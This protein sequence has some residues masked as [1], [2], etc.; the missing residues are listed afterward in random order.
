MAETLI[1][2]NPRSAN[3]RAGRNRQQ[4]E[5]VLRARLPFPFDVVYTERQGHATEIAREAAPRCERVV[6]LG[7]DGT[8]NEV[9][10]GLFADDRPV[11][12]DALLGIIRYG[13]GGDFARGLGIPK[14]LEGAID[15]LASGSP[16]EV[17]VGKVTYRRPDG[18][19]GVR[20][21]V[22]EGEIGMGA[23]VCEAVNHSSKGL[24]GS[25]SFMRAILSTMLRYPNQTVRLSLGGAPAE[26][27]LINNVW[28]A[29]GAYSGGGIRSAPRARLDDGLLDVVIVKGGNLLTKLLGI[30]ALRSGAFVKSKNVDYRTAS[31]VEAESDVPVPIEVEGEPIG[32]L[33]AVFEVIGA[34]LRVI[35]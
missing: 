24:G 2:V 19:E 14:S 28:V 25:L 29:N 22:N 10:N 15:R 20:Y 26:P 33:P 21:F 17:D 8:L 34:R 18:G 11:N 35:A 13:T 27:L 5:A 4:I 9:V 3:G 32:T 30:P 12:P 16:R 1:I 23:A 6:V 31:R 7:G